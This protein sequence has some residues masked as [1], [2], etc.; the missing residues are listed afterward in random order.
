LDIISSQEITD[1]CNKFPVSKVVQAASPTCKGND[2]EA[3]TAGPQNTL[4]G[5]GSGSKSSASPSKAGAVS[6]LY[7]RS[8]AVTGVLGVFAALLGM[9]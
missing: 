7:A 4:S 2:A 1:S 8:H 5:S 3:S 9:L 6:D